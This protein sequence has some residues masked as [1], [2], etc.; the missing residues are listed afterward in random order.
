MCI[1]DSTGCGEWDFSC[2]TYLVDSSKIENV[3]TS[4]ASHFIT[5]FDGDVFPYKETPVY[6]YLRGTQTDLEIVNTNSETAAVVGTGVNTLA[7]PLS[8]SNLAGKSHYLFT[9]AELMAGGLTAGNI[10]GLNLNVLG[11]A[12]EAKFLKIRLKHSNK[13][14]LN[15]AIDFDGFTEVYN[16][17]T[18]LTA[19]QP[20]R[21]NFHTPFVWDGSSNVLVEF[22]F[23]NLDATN[24]SATLVEGSTTAQNMGLSSTNEQEIILTNETYL[25][26]NDYRG[27]T[28]SQNRTIEAWIKTTDGS[29]GEIIGWGSI[30]T[31]RKWVFRLAEGQLRLEVH[32]GGTESTTTVDDGEWHHVACVLNGT[33]LGDISFYIDGVLD[34]N[35]TTGTTTLNT[36]ESPVRISRGLSNRYLD[37]TIDD[38]LSLI[39]I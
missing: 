35:S 24:P 19:N 15:G 13:T 31:G 21:F 11:N 22:N 38:V 1:R 8:T 17:N 39:H 16:K 18:S 6:N 29:D 28:G 14:A 32:G 25:E 2:N 36:T 26:C 37:A 23:T 7:R 5:N 10:A 33:N 34:V 12:G 20:N 30:I 3:P 27:I 4:I 9:A